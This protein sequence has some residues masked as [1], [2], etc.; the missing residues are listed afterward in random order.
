MHFNHICECSRYCSPHGRTDAQGDVATRATWLLLLKARSLNLYN[1]YVIHTYIQVFNLQQNAAKSIWDGVERQP[2]RGVISLI[3]YKPDLTDELNWKPCRALTH[4]HIWMWIFVNLYRVPSTIR[5]CIYDYGDGTTSW[6]LD[7]ECWQVT[8]AND[9][10]WKLNLVMPGKIVQPITQ[11]I[12]GY[13][14]ASAWISV[15][16][17]WWMPE[18]AVVLYVFFFLMTRCIDVS[19]KSIAH[20]HCRSWDACQE[21]QPPLNALRYRVVSRKCCHSKI[22][23]APSNKLGQLS[24]I[25]L[26]LSVNSVCAIKYHGEKDEAVWFHCSFFWDRVQPGTAS[27][28]G[29]VRPFLGL[30]ARR[31][32]KSTFPLDSRLMCYAWLWQKT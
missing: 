15:W 28:I 30:F 6:L 8:A 21:L 2:R 9:A 31:L 1:D 24:I 11:M 13:M 12:Y 22:S 32:R 17:C 20:S 26:D 16:G 14:V 27:A 7:L 10:K 19:K 18:C 29:C 5:C 4:A 23:G 25:S 3:A